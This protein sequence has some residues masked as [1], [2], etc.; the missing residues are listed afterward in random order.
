LQQR[1]STAGRDYV[2]K[3]HNWDRITSDLEVVYNKVVHR[4]HE[5]L[6]V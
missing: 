3:Y 4:K 6:N 2:E 5:L 1:L